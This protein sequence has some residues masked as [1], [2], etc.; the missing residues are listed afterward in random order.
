MPKDDVKARAWGNLIAAQGHKT[1]AKSRNQLATR[2]SAEHITQ[3]KKHAAELFDD[4]ESAKSEQLSRNFRKN[5]VNHPPDG[6]PFLFN[7][8][9]KIEAT[10]VTFRLTY[11]V[12]SMTANNVGCYR[13]C[14]KRGR[15]R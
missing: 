13:A 1:A 4:I 10:V 9:M 12:T 8:L 6:T 7:H 11:V 5:S 14:K 3:A 15:G 2:V